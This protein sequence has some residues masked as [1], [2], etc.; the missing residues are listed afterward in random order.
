MT[1]G[2]KSTAKKTAPKSPPFAT[3]VNDPELWMTVTDADLEKYATR[4]C[5][6]YGETGDNELVPALMAMYAAMVAKLSVERR[7][8]VMD[9]LAR[10]LPVGGESVNALLPFVREEP[11]LSVISG[12][13]I[14]IAM[15]MP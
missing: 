7:M 6:M 5:H 2:K 10:Q 3:L 1:M 13:A 15:L 8:H 12:A 4:L 11:D 9:Q 14:S